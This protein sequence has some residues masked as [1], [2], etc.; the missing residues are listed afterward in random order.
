MLFM[1][2]SFVVVR[3]FLGDFLD[4]GERCPILVRK[5]RVSCFETGAFWISSHPEKPGSLTPGSPTP[6]IVNWARLV[7]RAS[8]DTCLFYSTHLGLVPWTARAVAGVIASRLD[9]EPPGT[10]QILVGDFNS[11]PDGPLVRALLAGADSRGAWHDAW[12]G[13]ARREGAGGTFD[14][15]GKKEVRI[16]YVLTRPALEVPY[17]SLTFTLPGRPMASDHC[18]LAVELRVRTGS[19]R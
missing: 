6:H 10:T 11:R 16:D 8:G 2:L 3:F 1:L 7:D 14:W 13:A 18:L 19:Q 5:E 15:P 9:R 17:A 4:S 12:T